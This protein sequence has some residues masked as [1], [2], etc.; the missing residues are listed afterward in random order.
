MDPVLPHRLEIQSL[1]EEILGSS[2]VHFQQPS[3]DEMI[4]PAI[5]YTQDFE[6]VQFASNLPYRRDKRWQVTVIDRNPDSLIP[7]KIGDLP[8]SRFDRRY[9]KDNLHHFVYN[10]Y[11]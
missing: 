6:S 8:S 9:P 10:V 3:S 4:Y 7:D 11:F 1:L 2:E 5:L